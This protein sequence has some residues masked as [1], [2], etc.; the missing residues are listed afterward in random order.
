MLY[1]IPTHSVSERGCQ[2]IEA[3]IT[4]GQL[5]SPDLKSTDP[6]SI[7]NIRLFAVSE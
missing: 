7:I 5:V 3:A 4:L 6:K 1:E 2:C